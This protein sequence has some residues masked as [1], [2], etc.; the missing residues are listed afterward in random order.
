[1]RKALLTVLWLLVALAVPVGAGLDAACRLAHAQVAVAVSDHAAHHHHDEPDQ[2]SGDHHGGGVACCHMAGAN[3]AGLP[4]RAAPIVLA[5][6]NA[7][8]AYTQIV[9]ELSGH[10][11]PPPRDPPRA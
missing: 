8:T 3:A 11:P 6:S 9:V 2:S 5:P 4:A 10:D 1:M 7:Q